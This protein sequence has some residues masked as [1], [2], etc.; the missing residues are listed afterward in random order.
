MS[1]V[2]TVAPQ[3][4]Q[5]AQGAATVLAVPAATDNLVWVLVCNQTRQAA[6]VDGPDAAGALA[7]V[8][9]LGATL[10]AVLNTHTHGDHVGVNRDLAAKG[11]LN[12]LRVY[13]PAATPHAVPGL[14][15]PVDEGDVVEV[16]ALRLQVLRTEGHQF[17]HISF[18]IDDALFCGDTMFAGG[19][20]YLFDGPPE[21]MFRSLM[22][23]AGLPPDTKVCCAHEYTEDNLRFA[24]SVEPGNA[25]LIARSEDVARVRAEGRCTVP[26]TIEIE[27]ATNPFLRPGSPELLAQVR[28][29]TGQADLRDP[30]EVFAATRS[31]KDTGRYRDD[32]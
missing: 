23:L 16:G 29:Q 15:H 3:P 20:G 22:R 7:A 4:W 25:A 8:A 32:G 13:G 19:C 21:A 31:L 24:R 26:S 30:A 9:S 10:T 12:G 1:H 17:G 11:H 6:V 5:L 27:R 2:V 18:L 28:L 14:T